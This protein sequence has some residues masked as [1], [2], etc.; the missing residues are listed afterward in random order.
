MRNGGANPHGFVWIMSFGCA[1]VDRSQKSKE[2]ER[3]LSTIP[4]FSF[5]IKN[6]VAGI[7]KEHKITCR[8]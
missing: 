2:S 1:S 3:I 8:G 5:L 7:G 4:H 6:G